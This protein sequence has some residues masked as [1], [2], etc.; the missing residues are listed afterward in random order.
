MKRKH[1]PILTI[2]G[3]VLLTSLPLLIFLVFTRQQNPED[4]LAELTPPVPDSSAGSIN[5]VTERGGISR[6]AE[7]Q[8]EKVS[9][10]K[11]SERLAAQAGPGRDGSSQPLLAE[12]SRPTTA[13]TANPVREGT[14]ATARSID[15]DPVPVLMP[16]PA[17]PPSSGNPGADVSDVMDA[18]TRLAGSAG[19]RQ[20]HYQATGHLALLSSSAASEPAVSVPSSEQLM[21]AEQS[22][23]V[24]NDTAAKNDTPT[25]KSRE[26]RGQRSKA[27]RQ[28]ASDKSSELSTGNP[29]KAKDK[30]AVAADDDKQALIEDVLIQTPVEN[31][32][33]GRVENLLASTRAKGWPIALVRSDLPDDVWWVQQVVGIQG[34]SFAARVNFGN[35][36]SLSGSVYRMVI[37]FLDT[38]DEVRR[39]RIAKQFK[40]IP[41]GTRR[42]REFR[43]I[44]N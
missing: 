1:Y 8:P 5:A 35:E 19:F 16:V 40:E 24:K 22:T 31:S 9:P 34:N 26:G 44:R 42:S 11:T 14:D 12:A 15:V 43:Y 30:D 25:E 36:Y 37:V 10:P 17:S 6:A 28:V 23:A 20:N 39:F 2:V 3:A 7:T 32:S 33:V 27:D 21:P 13:P 38:P 4:Q 41:E 18:I 29:R